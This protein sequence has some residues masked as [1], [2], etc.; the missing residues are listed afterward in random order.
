MELVGGL[1]GSHL[2]P[3]K[4]GI[5]GFMIDSTWAVLVPVGLLVAQ[6]G[7]RVNCLVYTG[8]SSFFG[9]GFYKVY[10]VTLR[11]NARW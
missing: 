1:Y 8:L 5:A 9:M 6:Y 10:T 4:V 11:E 2:S 3:F 7:V